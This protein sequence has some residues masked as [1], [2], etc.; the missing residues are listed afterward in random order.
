M[1]QFLSLCMVMLLLAFSAHAQYSSQSGFGLYG[2]EN[3]MF[4]GGIGLTSIETDGESNLYYNFMMRPELSFGKFG[5]GL[6]INFNINT[7]TGELRKEDWDENYDYL[8]LIRYLRYG[9]KNDPFYTRLGALDAAR[10]GHGTIVNYYT[11]EAVYD[12]RKLGLAFD[13]D[14][15]TFGFE[16]LTNTFSR[17]ELIAGRGYLRPLRNAI[18]IPVIKNLAFGATFA[19]DFDPDERTSTDDGVSVYGLDTELPIFQNRF[20][21]TALYYD[22]SQIHGYSTIEDKSRSF[23]NGQAAG[24][25]FDFP[26]LSSIFD[27]TFKFERRWMSDEYIPSFFDAFYELQRYNNGLRK[28]DQLLS[29]TE[30][31]T[32]WFGELYTSML[33]NTIRGIGTFSRLDDTPE[34]GIMHLALNAPDAIPSIAA[35]ATYDKIGIEQLNDVFTL[36]NRSVARVGV[37]Y[38]LNAF[39]IMYVDY[40]WTYEKVNE[41]GNVYYKPQERFEPRLVFSYQ[42]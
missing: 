3:N 21:K 2:E 28:T 39:M 9:H 15:G 24:V 27:L 36:D 12:E 1:K 34:S 31:R 17:A 33:G 40:I 32:G 37:G 18:P 25:Q 23:G 8:R 30:D 10:L 14:M 4:F 5:V 29:I 16:T 20:L 11:N 22:W 19:R 42:F 6:N 41:N 7:K 35:H 13:M 38:K 26:A